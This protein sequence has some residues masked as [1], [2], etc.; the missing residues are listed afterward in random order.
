MSS[1]EAEDDA[2]LGRQAFRTSVP[3]LPANIN[4]LI[5]IIAVN[6]QVTITRATLLEQTGLTLSCACRL[7]QV[8]A[9]NRHAC[10]LLQADARDRDDLFLRTSTCPTRV[11]FTSAFDIECPLPL[12]RKVKAAFY[13]N[14]K[15]WVG[16]CLLAV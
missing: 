9:L 14:S 16:G 5:T 11:W 15:A 2:E 13:T 12:L 6:S 1:G 7:Y 4:S 8:L 3:L 10:P